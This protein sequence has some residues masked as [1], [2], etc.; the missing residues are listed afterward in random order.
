MRRRL[1][2]LLVLLLFPSTAGA[3]PV[4]VLTPAGHAVHRN[5]PYLTMPAVTP[6]PAAAAVTATSK[7][8]P[9]ANE[10]TVRTEL[11]R[12]RNSRAITSTQYRVYNGSFSAA[13]A[14]EKRLRGTR[15]QLSGSDP[16]TMFDGDTLYGALNRGE[17]VAARNRR[18]GTG[19]FER[20]IGWN[21]P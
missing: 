9:K 18:N 8:K 2:G 4:V 15:Q 6:A 3:A 17:H 20:E 7:P 13:L 1:F 11:V 14:S 16:V 12:L 21:Q 10:R 19:R 5:D